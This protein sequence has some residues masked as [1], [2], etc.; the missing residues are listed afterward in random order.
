M[1]LTIIADSL[2]LLIRISIALIAIV[3]SYY[4]GGLLSNYVRKT[5]VRVAPEVIYNLA[6]AIK[7]VFLFIGFLVALSVVGVEIS[8]LLIAAGFAGIVVGLATQQTLSQVFA[9]LSMLV[10]GRVR[11]GD[12]VRVGDDWGVVEAVGI[13]STQIRLW[14]GEV[15]TIPNSDLMS[16]KIYNY[17]KLIARRVEISVGISYRSDVS[18]ALN[19]I[20]TLLEDKELVLAEPPPTLIVDSLD[21]YAV[22]IRI[23]FWVPSQEFW[24]VRREILREIKEA[25]EAN[26][27]EIPFPQRVVWLQKGIS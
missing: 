18:R 21:E 26:G 9:G 19:V 1:P 10:E 2:E 27:I 6:R 3:I 5:K 15:V 13:M 8:G 11:V 14:S 4:L 24:T 12:S 16:S 22:K 25:L 7:L 17:S 23:L 20:R